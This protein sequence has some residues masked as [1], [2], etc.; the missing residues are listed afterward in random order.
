MMA[1]NGEGLDAQQIIDNSKVYTTR[2]CVSCRSNRRP[3][4]VLEKG[5]NYE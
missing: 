1:S 3:R 2:K 4:Y 5:V